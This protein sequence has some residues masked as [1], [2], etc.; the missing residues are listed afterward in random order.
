MKTTN[1][2]PFRLAAP[3]LC[4]VLFAAPFVPS[5]QAKDS[6]AAVLKKQLDSA[7]AALGQ[8]KAAAKRL[9]QERLE[10]VAQT[11]SL[12]KK[13]AGLQ[14]A[15]KG[16]EEAKKKGDAPKEDIESVKKQAR[17]MMEA[18]NKRQRELQAVI[19]DLQAKLKKAEAEASRVNDVLKGNSRC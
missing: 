2:R 19:R 15:E 12:R 14:A 13:L 11:D 9:A 8:S 5:L 6:D 3:V 17:E 18:N 16:S 7:R 1:F 10:L 4:A